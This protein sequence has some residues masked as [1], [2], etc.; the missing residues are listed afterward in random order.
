MNPYLYNKSSGIQSLCQSLYQSLIHI[1]NINLEF[2]PTSKEKFNP[3]SWDQLN[4]NTTVNPQFFND[5]RFKLTFA[6]L[7]ISSENVL[8]EIKIILNCQLDGKNS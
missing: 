5:T 3:K 7:E 4:L 8:M 2:L 6:A 1:R